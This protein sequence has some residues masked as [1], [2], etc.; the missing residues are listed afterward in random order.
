VPAARHKQ[1]AHR[2]LYGLN[3]YYVRHYQSGS[4]QLLDEQ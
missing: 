2:L 3:H 1:Y 4:R